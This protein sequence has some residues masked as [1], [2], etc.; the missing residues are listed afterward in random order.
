MSSNSGTP[1]IFS[2]SDHSHL[3]PY[4][5]ALHASCISHDRILAEFL[6][7]LSH[8]KLLGWWKERIA[9][10]TAGT[11]L[12]LILLDES[13]PCARAKGTELMGVAMLFMPYS[14]TGPFRG[15]VEKLLV[16]PKFR[17]RGGA[18]MLMSALEGESIRRGRTLLMLDTEAGSPA[19]DVFRK[20]GYIEVGRIPNFGVSPAVPRQLKDEVFFY[21]Q[22]HT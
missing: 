18:R 19:E 20:F 15:Y 2:P 22:L 14:E 9:E 11:R 5:A 3:V 10:V 7:P 8:E 4:L 13:E 21:K 12:M 17:R 16:S 6:P 1:Y